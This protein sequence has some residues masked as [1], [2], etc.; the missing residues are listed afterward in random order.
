M[1]GKPLVFSPATPLISLKGSISGKFIWIGC[2]DVKFSTRLLSCAEDMPNDV[3]ITRKKNI[4]T[5]FIE[6]PQIF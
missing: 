6:I 3:T 4:F 2:K 5:I 1:A